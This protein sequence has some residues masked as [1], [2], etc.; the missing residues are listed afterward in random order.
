MAKVVIG[1]DDQFIIRD[2]MRVAVTAPSLSSS[3]R[4]AV[5]AGFDQSAR[6]RRGAFGESTLRIGDAADRLLLGKIVDAPGLTAQLS[7][8]AAG[9]LAGATA[10]PDTFACIR[11]RRTDTGADDRLGDSGQ[12]AGRDR[13]QEQQ[14]RQT[15]H[16][17]RS[18]V[19]AAPM[20]R[21][22]LNPR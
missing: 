6:R 7:R 18:L 3:T 2:E 8:L 11:Q 12:G 22:P 16:R 4:S 9:Q 21:R 17:H 15:P 13:R 20:W 19:V 5:A 1:Y 10:F 14:D